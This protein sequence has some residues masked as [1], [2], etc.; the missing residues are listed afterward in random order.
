VSGSATRPLNGPSCGG[1][2][3]RGPRD[4][5][6]HRRDA[7]RIEGHLAFPLQGAYWRRG[8]VT[9]RRRR[10]RSAL[11]ASQG[12]A[13][14]AVYRLLGGARATACSSTGHAAAPTRRD[15]DRGGALRGARLQGSRAA[16]RRTGSGRDLRASGAAPCPTSGRA[17]LPPED[18]WAARST[19]SRCRASSSGSP[20]ARPRLHLLHDAI[21]ADSIERRDWQVARAPSPLL[22]GR[23]FRPSCRR[24][25]II[26]QHTTCRSRSARSSRPSRLPDAHHGAAHRLHPHDGGPRGGITHSADRSPGRALSSAHRSHG[27]TDLS[28]VC[29]AAAL[30]FDYQRHNFGIQEYMRHSRRHRSRV[31]HAYAVRRRCARSGRRAR[32]GVEIDE[33][34]WRPLPYQRAYLPHQPKADGTSTAGER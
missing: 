7:R 34:P 5:A 29:M 11:W 9:M 14:R 25:R 1:D 26:R 30:H 10:G 33:A 28:P 3:S 15:R 27:A 31:P 6:P 8:P 17:G 24:I 32:P 18:R 21:I 19:S 13:R 20:G 2:L 23:P 12:S 16:G 4:P 22:A